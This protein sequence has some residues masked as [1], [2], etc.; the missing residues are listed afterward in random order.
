MAMELA[1]RLRSFTVSVNRPGVKRDAC[2]LSQAPSL[3]IGSTTAR[4]VQAA[5]VTLKFLRPRT[6]TTR[7]C[8]LSGWPFGAAPTSGKPPAH[9][10]WTWIDRPGN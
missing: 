9:R 1:Q 8:A 10:R 4:D 3:E 6:A 5:M 7:L 2:S